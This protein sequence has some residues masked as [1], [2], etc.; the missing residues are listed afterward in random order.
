MTTGWEKSDG[1]VPRASGAAP[2]TRVALTLL[3]PALIILT[4]ATG[5][6]DSRATRPG[7]FD[8]AFHVRPDK[9]RQVNLATRGEGAEMPQRVIIIREEST[10]A[11]ISNLTSAREQ[12]AERPAD[13]L[14]LLITPEMAA[15]AADDMR[16]LAEAIGR[17]ST[18]VETYVQPSGRKK[19]AEDASK[20]F[21]IIYRVDHGVEAADP[22]P[23][24]RATQQHLS[25]GA[26]LARS[27]MEYVAAQSA[28]GRMFKDGR[29]LYN[30]ERR[31]LVV[32]FAM[33][34]VFQAADLR[35][36][37][38]AVEEVMAIMEQGPM[39]AVIVQG[40]IE[41][42]M[43]ELRQRAERDERPIRRDELTVYLDVMPRMLQNMARLLDQWDKFYLVVMEMAEVDGQTVGSLVVDV[44][45]GY[46]VRIDELHDLAPVLT[47]KGR[48]RLTFWQEEPAGQAEAE[49]S[50]IHVQCVSERGG[51]AAIRFEKWFYG[52]AG[53]LAFP[54]D[55]WA[56]HS[57]DLVTRKT[58]PHAKVTTVTVLMNLVD[59]APGE[60]TRRILRVTQERRLNVE[61]QGEQVDRFADVE[62]TIEFLSP[63]KV[64]YDTSTSRTRL[65]GP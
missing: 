48:F 21:A 13:G 27:V 28:P 1:S 12:I 42:K 25:Q 38:G 43:L 9:W 31:R 37:D 63:E 26:P 8:A 44:R 65:P 61:T 3:L 23:Y 15:D 46:E 52:L 14:R 55:D 2:E 53:L 62:R 54:L 5:C 45:P 22:R 50:V 16:Q 18:Q 29:L 24:A 35:I 19:W 49:E 20:V 60:D 41:Q 30:E 64:W 6:M 58:A 39:S 11:S 32:K 7:E 33:A 47:A 4:A 51:Q 59:Y 40:M 36:P 56:L 34:G 10:W 17:W 57:V